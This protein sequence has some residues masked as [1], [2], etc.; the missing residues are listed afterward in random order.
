MSINK[1]ALRNKAIEAKETDDW[2]CDDGN[3]HDLATPDAVLSLLDELEVAEKRIAELEKS[4]KSWSELASDIEVYRK[5]WADNA[6]K[7]GQKVIEKD[8][9]IAELEAREVEIPPFD[10]YAS[11]VSK[12]L[13]GA[14][15][16]ACGNAGIKIKGE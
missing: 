2:G 9:Y 7:L 6:I 5:S 3:F 4:K 10:G 13:Q 1:Q 12:E 11:H 8:K 14:F 15:S 16:I